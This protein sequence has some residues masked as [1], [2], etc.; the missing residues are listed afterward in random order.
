LRSF[1]IRAALLAAAFWAP[2]AAQTVPTGGTVQQPAA[3]APSRPAT[4]PVVEGPLLDAPVSRTAYPLGP[5]DVL[6]IGVF[7]DVSET[8]TVTVSPE[9]AALVPGMGSVTVLGLNLDQAESRVRAL[10]GRYYLNAQVSVNLARVR[11]FKVYVVGWVDRPGVRQASATTRVSEVVP[12][13]DPGAPR[14]RNVVLRRAG[15]DSVHVDLVRF[16]QT[17]DVRFNPTLREGDAVVVPTIDHVVTLY[18]VVRFPGVYEFRRGETLAEILAVANAEAGFPSRAADTVRI[19][20]Q[21][22]VSERTVIVMSTQEATGARGAGFALRPFDAIFVAGMANFGEQSFA[23]VAGQV[24]RPGAYPIRPDTTTVR[25]LL[26]MAGGLT[27]RASLASATLR[28]V[29]PDAAAGRQ[30][31]AGALGPEETLSPEERRV[32]AAWERGDASLVALDFADPVRGARALEQTL[33]PGDMLTVPERR[34]DV[35]VTGAVLRPGLV[36]YTA[37]ADA[38]TYLSQAGWYTRRAAWKE[39]V[40]IRARTGAQLTAAEA[41]PLEPGDTVVVP[42]RAPID[43]T[44]RLQVLAAIAT[45]ITGLALTATTLF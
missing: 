26:A 29:G 4:Q 33:R 18:G 1:S 25:E 2:A 19:S 27:E 38:R 35:L 43:W 20:R 7:G 15:G 37:G 24:S 22:G 30:A 13:A 39:T 5:G 42:F 36:N 31:T 16:I 34:A 6:S 12:Q 21:V 17:G 32:M 11:S 9:G 44:G 41:G 10:V 23:T 28:R 14:R 8:H 45:S 3:E 40:V